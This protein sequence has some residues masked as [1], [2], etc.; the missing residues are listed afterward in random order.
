PVQSVIAHVRSGKL[1]ALA[2]SGRKRSPVLPD[3]P[4]LEEAGIK[5]FETT[6]WWAV[7]GPAGIPAEIADKLRA[8][9]ERVARSDAFR[10]KL[11][12][13]GVAWLESLAAAK[14]G[15]R[16]VRIPTITDPRG[17]D[18]TKAKQLKQADW[19]LELERRAIAAF[20]KLGVSMTDTCINYQTVLAATRG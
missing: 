13:A 8:E 3:V 16:T 14:T 7:F 11:G 15:R 10:E 18:F 9:I 17:T 5:D 12:T 19:M 4:T 1:R 6:A 2:V 20:V